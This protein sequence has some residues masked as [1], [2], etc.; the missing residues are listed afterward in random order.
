VPIFLL[1]GRELLFATSTSKNCHPE[2]SEGP[3]FSGQQRSRE[4]YL[5]RR[6]NSRHESNHNRLINDATYPAPKPL[7]MLT[8]LTFDAQEF[9]IPSRAVKPLNDAP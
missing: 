3:A 5:T 6:T 4:L 1:G 2:R 9:I 8:T 7:S